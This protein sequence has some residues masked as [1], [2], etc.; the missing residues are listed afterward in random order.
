MGVSYKGPP[1]GFMVLHQHHPTLYYKVESDGG[2]IVTGEKFKILFSETLAD[3][4]IIKGG[5]NDKGFLF[6]DRKRPK[7]P[8]R[9]PLRWFTEAEI[10]K[11]IDPPYKRRKQ[12]TPPP[13]KVLKTKHLPETPGMTQ[14]TQALLE[15]FKRGE[16]HTETQGRYHIVYNNEEEGRARSAP[17]V[18]ARAVI[19]RLEAEVKRKDRAYADLQKQFAKAKQQQDVLNAEIH[20]IRNA[21]IEAE[22]QAKA[23][24]Q[25]L[26][27]DYARRRNIRRWQLEAV[28]TKAY[29]V[30]GLVADSWEIEDPQG[31]L[32]YIVITRTSGGTAD[33]T[34]T[35]WLEDLRHIMDAR[36]GEDTITYVNAPSDC[37]VNVLEILPGYEEEEDDGIE[38]F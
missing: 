34:A 7:H 33:R 29:E 30:E 17:P 5:I 6:G 25:E 20:N 37:A 8:K 2:V 31:Q 16:S 18:P 24:V 32:R 4:S 23:R 28:K 3:G 19:D 12:I 35:Q 13:G 1:S 15:S 36:G 9:Y 22:A 21:K 38:H 10:A 27:D 14:D 26:R 11:G